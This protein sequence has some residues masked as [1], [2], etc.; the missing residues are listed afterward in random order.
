MIFKAYKPNAKNSNARNNLDFMRVFL[1]IRQSRNKWKKSSAGCIDVMLGVKAALVR[2]VTFRLCL[3]T[4]PGSLQDAPGTAASL[5][6]NDALKSSRS[7]FVL[8]RKKERNATQ[9]K[10]AQ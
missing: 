4:R 2:P 9:V 7:N 1:A 8:R 10:L 5:N 3:F 6:S